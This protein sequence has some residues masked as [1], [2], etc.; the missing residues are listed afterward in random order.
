M[1]ELSSHLSISGTTTI[2][3]LKPFADRHIL[4]IVRPSRQHGRWLLV[5][6]CHTGLVRVGL[7]IGCRVALGTVADGCEIWD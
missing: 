7:G 3:V 1:N 2:W 5:L 4:D 6:G